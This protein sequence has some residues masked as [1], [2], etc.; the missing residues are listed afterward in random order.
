MA[1]AVAAELKVK[2]G[3]GAEFE[4]LFRTLDEYVQTREP[5]T[6]FYQLCKKDDETYIVLEV[7]ENQ[8]AVDAHSNSALYKEFFK[9]SG[10][11][12]AGKPEFIVCSTVGNDG[13]KDIS[14]ASVAVLAHLEMQRGKGK[15]FESIFQDLSESVHSKEPD[16]LYYQLCRHQSNPDSF[17]AFEL[18]KDRKALMRHSKTSHFSA[19]SA[20]FAPLLNAKPK[21]VTMQPVGAL[22]SKL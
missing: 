15:Q 19:A 10:R 18:Y 7:Y 20:K 1:L 5:G 6:L 17:S 2:A 13:R 16:C 11:F 9:K 4:K 14:G 8:A 3:V 21:I 12:L 22:Q